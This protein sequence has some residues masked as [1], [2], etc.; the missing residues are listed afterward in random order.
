MNIY[1]LTQLYEKDLTLTISLVIV[2]LRSSEFQFKQ[3]GGHTD[4][5][6][7]KDSYQF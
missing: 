2:V 3:E 7:G 4:E 1:L 5:T 6:L